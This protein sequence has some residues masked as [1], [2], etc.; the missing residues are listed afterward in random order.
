V[1]IVMQLADMPC[2]ILLM[3]PLKPPFHPFT[4][5]FFPPHPPFTTQNTKKFRLGYT[6]D[7]VLFILHE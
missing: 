7:G 6:L 2:Q 5:H 3:K 4:N 1:T